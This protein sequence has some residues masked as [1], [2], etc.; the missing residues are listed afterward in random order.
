MAE[1]F[2]PEIG[3]DIGSSNVRTTTGVSIDLSGAGSALGKM[4]SK[5]EVK[6]TEA[7]IKR[8]R[9]MPLQESWKRIDE[10]DLPV[11]QKK[12]MKSVV[13]SQFIGANIDLSS[14]VTAALNAT[15][16]IESPAEGMMSPAQLMIKDFEADDA[17]KDIVGSFKLQALND[18]GTFDDA[19]Y[20]NLVLGEMQRTYESKRLKK[21]TEDLMSADKV[22]SEASFFGVPGQEKPSISDQW[23]TLSQQDADQY[24]NAEIATKF[25]V[26][27]EGAIDLPEAAAQ[28]AGLL[29]QRKAE[30]K[31]I[32]MEALRKTGL[33][34]TDPKVEKELAVIL[35]PYDRKI[36]LLKQPAE[37]LKVLAADLKNMSDALKARQDISA[38]RGADI[39]NSVIE[40]ATG[41]QGVGYMPEVKAAF[42]TKLTLDGRVDEALTQFVVKNG[43]TPAQAIVT[44]PQALLGLKYSDVTRPYT[45]LGP[46]GTPVQSQPG[47]VSPDVDARIAAMSETDRVKTINA[48]VATMASASSLS[49]EQLE[50][51]LPTIHDGLVIMQKTEQKLDTGQLKYMF[52]RDFFKLVENTA[53]KRP[54]V[55]PAFAANADVAIVDQI[56]RNVA[57]IRRSLE[58]V[59]EAVGFKVFKLVVNKGNLEITIDPE[60]IKKNQKLRSIIADVGSEDATKVIKAFESRGFVGAMLGT[61]GTSPVSISTSL[62]NINYLTANI[63]TLD[64]QLQQLFPK[65]LTKLKAEM[66]EFNTLNYRGMVAEEITTKFAATK[67]LPQDLSSNPDA[68]IVG[69]VAGKIKAQTATEQDLLRSDEAMKRLEAAGIRIP[70]EQ[71]PNLT[72]LYEASQSV[73]SPVANTPPAQGPKRFR[74][75]GTSLEEV[76]P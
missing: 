47:D 28:A 1:A 73:S 5:P 68:L 39:L 60:A 52:G 42:G 12:V 3:M 46:D 64:P 13:S 22:Q 6:M 45:T 25:V 38:A 30:Q 75:N 41:L 2:A 71:I 35:S 15:E 66:E 54:D 29:E 49:P 26:N 10:S 70:I 67:A 50:F 4:F 36:A 48:A 59:E 74:L 62:D 11:S 27:L 53:A 18:D 14:D 61:K 72:T 63:L 8:Q 56:G 44:S 57:D 16:G 31:Q 37:D 58:A 9:L 17:N 43:Q 20:S 69:E 51:A 65:S 21:A 40:S 33:D 55:A 23:A 34:L 7:E 32:M 24:F 19:K 76:S